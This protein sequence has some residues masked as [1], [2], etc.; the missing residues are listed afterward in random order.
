MDRPWWN[1]S[2][3]GSGSG[4]IRREGVVGEQ[5]IVGLGVNRCRADWHA[6]RQPGTPVN[7]F[8]TPM[9]LTNFSAA[10]FLA[11]LPAMAQ[12]Q[13]PQLGYM[14]DSGGALRPVFGIAAS[15]TLGYPAGYPALASAASFACSST[16]CLA[17]TDAAVVAFVPS[18]GN[19]QSAPVVLP[20]SVTPC[21]CPG[22]A[23]IALDPVALADG[24]AWIYFQ[25]S[26]Q[27]ARWQNG[28]LNAIDFSLG[29][30]VLS[31]RA[32]PD[33][34]DYVIVRDSFGRRATTVWIE[35]YSVSDA[36]VAVVDSMDA[37]GTVMLLDHGILLSSSEQVTLRR[38][39][40][41]ELAFP[42]AGAKT[43]M[44]A[45][46][47]YVEISASAGM[48]ILRTDSGKEQ[49]SLLPGTPSAEV[50][51]ATP[52]AVTNGATPGAVTRGAAVQ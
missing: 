26:R 17:K 3:G 33:G 21:A 40:G 28:V 13:Q 35:H 39:S 46:D 11:A 48:W 49:L 8:K 6:E 43:F 4:G 12:I 50:T 9:T 36:S 10:I 15:A 1:G 32:T 5:R 41:Q 37:M 29:G 19:G 42:L 7:P 25:G 24:G 30:E 2:G 47:S 18:E 34:F 23:L 14:L 22:P 20:P 16:L 27:L 52:G 31:L 45:G 38:A 51:G 44:A